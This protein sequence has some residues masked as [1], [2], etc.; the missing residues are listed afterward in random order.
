MEQ[1]LRGGEG[2]SANGWLCTTLCTHGTKV[3]QAGGKLLESSRQPCNS[4]S[5]HT[6][7]TAFP[8]GRE[9]RELGRLQKVITASQSG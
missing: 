7:A 1:E 6:P 2:V 3:H 4:Q 5:L 8:S 9:L